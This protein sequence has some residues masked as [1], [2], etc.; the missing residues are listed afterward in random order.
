MDR[1]PVPRRDPL[2]H[3]RW[4][5]A[6]GAE[7]FGSGLTKLSSAWSSP[8]WHR[9]CTST[10][11]GVMMPTDTAN[12]AGRRRASP[13]CGRI[14]ACSTYPQSGWRPAI[15]MWCWQ[16]ADDALSKAIVVGRGGSIAV[17][18]PS[19]AVS[20]NANVACHVVGRFAPRL[21][22]RGTRVSTTLAV[23]SPTVSTVSHGVSGAS[24]V[25]APRMVTGA[26]ISCMD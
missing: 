23:A 2:T 8:T 18:L 12:A 6:A 1:G 21:A 7:A 17:P 9:R 3:L 5:S 16:A 26:C 11:G 24:R 15:A 22:R 25:R 13:S 4:P 19:P 10:C 14:V 20:S